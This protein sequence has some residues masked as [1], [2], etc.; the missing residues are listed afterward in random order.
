MDFNE[1][2]DAMD[3]VPLRLAVAYKCLDLF[4][5]NIEEGEKRGIYFG[6]CFFDGKPP[7]ETLEA[8]RKFLKEQ[9]SRLR[10][11]TEEAALRPVSISQY[12]K[13]M[14]FLYQKIVEHGL[15]NDSQRRDILA[16]MD[17]CEYVVL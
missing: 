6:K 11:A 3:E 4:K 13:I 10:K 1:E 9:K 5:I 12:A 8:I 16:F 15:F 14:W 17:I 2:F 7:I